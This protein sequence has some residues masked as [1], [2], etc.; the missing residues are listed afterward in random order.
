MF[1]AALLLALLFADQDT[2][3]APE[4]LLGAWSCDGGPCIDPQIEF[5]V[6]DGRHVFRSWLHERPSIV[7]RWVADGPA[8]TIVCCSGVVMS[9]KIVSVDAMELVLR[10]DHERRS[11]RYKRMKQ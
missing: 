11:A 6:E 10:G 9:Y 8:I 3:P 1:T 2:P 5:A 7:G 4:P